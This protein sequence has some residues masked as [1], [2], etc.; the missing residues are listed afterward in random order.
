MNIHRLAY[1]L[2]DFI[3]PSLQAYICKEEG[4]VD[5]FSKYSDRQLHDLFTFCLSQS[6]FRKDVT[7]FEGKSQLLKKAEAV[8]QACRKKDIAILT[9]DDPSYPVRLK[10]IF[11]P[12]QVLYL[13][14]ALPGSTDKINKKNIAVVGTR[15]PES[16]SVDFTKS[17]CQELS[18]LGFTI[19]SGMALGIDTSAHVVSVGSNGNTIAVLGCGVDVIYPYSNRSLYKKIIN[20]GGCIVSEFPPGVKPYKHHFPMR[21]RLISGLAD[22]VLMVQAA[23]RSGALITVRYALEQNKDIYVYS[24]MPGHELFKGN[25]VLIE[26]GAVR[27]TCGFDFLSSAGYINDNYCVDNTYNKSQNI[28]LKNRILEHI[29]GTPVS[30]KEIATRVCEKAENLS[31][32]IMALVLAG[33]IKEASGLRYYRII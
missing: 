3:T 16:F 32:D 24:G 7:E 5:L 12:P 17:F 26:D 18:E 27:V 15:R 10:H 21:N 9:Y 33:E 23:K 25:D 28:T 8:M 1:S 30:I 31:A 22:A 2:S 4:P 11:N 20:Q 14:G 6:N 19:V 29:S 13:K